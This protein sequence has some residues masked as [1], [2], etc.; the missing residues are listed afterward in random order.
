MNI[1]KYKRG[2][3]VVLYEMITLKRLFNGKTSFETQSEILNFKSD[4][5][6]HLAQNASKHF[7]NLMEK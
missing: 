2:L 5:L 3:G 4:N 1:N 6:K 7:L